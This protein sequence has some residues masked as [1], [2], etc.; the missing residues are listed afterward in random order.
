MNQQSARLLIFVLL[1][2]SAKFK[3]V[4]EGPCASII[5]HCKSHLNSVHEN[6]SLYSTSVQIDV[7]RMEYE[8]YKKQCF[9][10]LSKNYSNIYFGKR[11]YILVIF[12]LNKYV[13]LFYQKTSQKHA[14]INQSY[15]ALH[16]YFSYFVQQLS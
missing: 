5:C 16:D 1:I 4:S 12:S 15:I 2:T 11:S 7:P 13:A 6:K 10:F 3:I 8:K 9:V 14:L